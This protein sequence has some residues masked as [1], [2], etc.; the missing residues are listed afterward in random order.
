MPTQQ[1]RSLSSM[2]LL[3]VFLALAFSIGIANP[4]HSNAPIVHVTSGTLAGRLQG[5]T[6]IFE[7]IPFAAPPLGN[8]RWR[9]P[10]PVANWPGT[11]E[12][13]RSA[14]PCTQ[15]TTGPGLDA[16]LAPLAATYETP[17][18]VQSYKSSEDCLYL[19][20]F[21]PWP[22]APKGLPVM[23]WLHGGSNRVGTGADESY[24]GS[25]LASHGV[26]VVTLNYRLGVMG[27][28]A[29]PEL[30]AESPHH[31]SGNYG[32]LDQIA[33]LKWVQQNI[34]QFGG[35]PEN[36]TLFGESAGSIDATTLMTSP[37]VKGLFRRVIA[38]SGPAF[39]LGPALTL[40]EAQA[41]GAAVGQSAAGEFATHAKALETLRQMRADQVADLDRDIVASRYKN[42][43]PNGSVVDG[44]LLPQPPAKAFA[45]GKIQRV[46]FLAGLNGR[47]LSAFRIGAAAAAKQSA[48]PS[49]T[50]GPTAAAKKLADTAHPLYGTWTNTAVAVYL[51]QILVHGD[52]AIDRASNDMLMACPIGAETALVKSAGARAF[53]Y[54]FDRSIPGKGESKL[55]AFH[56][57]EVPYVFNT[58]TA[59]GW[60]WLP[61]TET[62]RKLSAMMEIYWT[63]FAK[64]GDPNEPGLPTW[65]PWNNGEEPYLEFSQSGA[66][67]PQSNFSPPFCHLAPHGLQER[68]VGN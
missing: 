41:V 40:A 36:V 11:R 54:R 55:G 49:Q 52:I 22:S 43:D 14:S 61:F 21:A 63:N 32:L 29:H 31:S 10:Q 65:K 7:G 35:D 25:S 62:D 26:I 15:S 1:E 30:T 64:S 6:A 19:N 44:W 20:V 3:L 56:G 47:E 51:A 46:D 66:A 34:A 2:C 9:E 5:G 53:L 17:F 24:N 67:V 13:T 68:L 8:L 37:L 48:K 58:F 12:A 42:F 59:R 50:D 39:G 28:F 38:E 23:V 57:L 45:W 18:A 4:P 60:R 16:Y 27:F 33:G